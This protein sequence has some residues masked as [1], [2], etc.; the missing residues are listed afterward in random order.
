MHTKQFVLIIAI[1]SLVACS[2]SEKCR[3]TPGDN[4]TTENPEKD[5][6][7]KPASEKIAEK[8][9]PVTPV[10]IESK[11]VTP[12]D[13]TKPLAV[14][15][16][17]DAITEE[18]DKCRSEWQILKKGWDLKCVAKVP[19]E[20]TACGCGCCGGIKNNNPATCLYFK[21]GD[22]IREIIK[23]DKK[24]TTPE[25]CATIGCSL[26]KKYKYCD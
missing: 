1:T 14:G 6:I 17:C 21:N 7:E 24:G 8:K 4:N 3:T 25:E 26:G 16:C 18:C 9:P 19:R 23:L 12:L 11:K 15:S 20:Y 5:R 10:A 13:C 2:G 22:D